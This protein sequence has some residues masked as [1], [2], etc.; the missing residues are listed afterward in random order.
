MD[1]KSGYPFWA[2]KNGLLV[3]FPQ[4]THDHRCDVVVIGGG[5]TGALIA[6][7]L[8]RHGHHV[9]VL[10]RRDIG[11]GSSAAS[12]ALLQY[13]IDTHLVELARRYDEPR[14]VRAYQGC[15]EAIGALETLASELG[16]V[17][18]ERH[19][20]L[21][22]A[23]NDED[24]ASLEAEY[25]LRDKHGFDMQWLDREAL[26]ARYGIEAPCA[27]L[28]KLA[29][30]LDPYRMAYRLF[31][32]VLEHGGE[33]FDRTEVADIEPHE[34]GVTVTLKNGATI[35]AGKVVMAAGYE[36]QAWLPE[37]VAKNRSSYAFVT[38][39]IAP[40]VL[41]ELRHTLVW[42][43]A[44][45]YLYMRSTDEGRLL[46]G[47]DDD[48]HDDPERRDARVMDKAHGLA[49]KVEAIWPSL[50]INPTFSWGGTFA[51]TDDGLPFFGPHESLGPH[52]HF[53]MAYGGNGITYSMMGAGLLRALIEG[54]DHALA[55]FFSFQ[56]PSEPSHEP[57]TVSAR[58]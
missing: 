50:S 52:V 34:S 27:I 1:L 55:E 7:E 36:S 31:E 35:R 48:D 25:A 51:E 23:S 9:V 22:F 47:G 5:I 39:P 26:S 10:E 43:S 21:Y 6:D 17:S 24:A 38:D 11:W 40:E 49:R 30:S 18:F 14:A 57:D 42:E 32:R 19:E 37:P 15:A 13:E 8:A 46:V 12:T 29:A 45:P 20:S 2:V 3:S 28:S 44:R 56:R 4:L 58:A 54:R 16:D 41:G 33:V 53:A